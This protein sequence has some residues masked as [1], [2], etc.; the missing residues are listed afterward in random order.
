MAT[1]IKLAWRNVWRNRR[2]TLITVSAIVF[3]VVAAVFMQSINRGSHEMM[4]DN[5]LRFSTGYLQLQ[6]YRH[7]DEPSLDNTFAYDRSMHQRVLETDPRIQAVLPRLETFMLAANHESTRGAVVFG[8]DPQK[9]HHFNRIKDRLVKGRFFEPEQAEAV[10]GGQLAR[11]LQLET[12]DELALIGQGRF[13]MSASGLFKIVGMIEHPLRE[14]NE[15]AV[16]LP[17]PAAQ[18]LL[19]AEGLVSAL[20]IAPEHDRHT[21]AVAAALRDRF[22]DHDLV[23]RTWP[24]LLPEL[25]ELFEF[26]LAGPRLLALVLYIVIG[27][28]F[29]GTVLT[30]TMERLREFGML[31][32]IGMRRGRLALVACIETLFIGIV[33]VLTGLATA[34]LVVYYFHRHPIELTGDAARAVAD[35]GWDPV[36]PMSFAADQFYTQGIYVFVLN[37]LIFLFPLWKI[38]RLDILEA[39]RK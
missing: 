37:M 9:E 18:E 35:M 32:S 7:Q 38:I 36:L 27:F 13:G 2:R 33:G 16:F 20:L 12:G 3:A 11:R 8:I 31:L 17:L 28:G 34:W 14:M 25:L 22:G 15:Q 26:D 30:M 19:S 21:P 1:Y 39:A 5:M 23:V 24:D 29:F 10:I 6:D 4:L